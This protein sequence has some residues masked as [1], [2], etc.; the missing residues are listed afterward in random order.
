MIAGT[1]SAGDVVQLDPE[2]HLGE[3]QG[4]FAGC[5]MV[6]TEVKAWGAQGYI[7]MPGTRGEPPGAAY[8]RAKWEEMEYVG[9]AQWV[10]P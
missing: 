1:L 6:V 9:R 4:F 3:K 10:Q 8:Y 7:C 5:F 2:A